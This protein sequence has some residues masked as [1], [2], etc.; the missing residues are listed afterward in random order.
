[1]ATGLTEG[2]FIGAMVDSYYLDMRD[3]AIE[4]TKLGAPVWMVSFAEHSPPLTLVPPGATEKH[5]ILQQI[6]Q[7]EKKSNPSTRPC[8]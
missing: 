7:T 5:P 3:L 1:M 6:L 4:I 8:R 2:H